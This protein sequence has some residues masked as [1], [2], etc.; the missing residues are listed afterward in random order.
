MTIPP[1]GHAPSPTT[2]GAAGRH[3]AATAEPDGLNTAQL[4]VPGPH[5][6][7][8]VAASQGESPGHA[9]RAPRTTAERQG[10]SLRAGDLIPVQTWAGPAFA[11]PGS[12]GLP[13]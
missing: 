8:D 13:S 1:R 10:L 11:Q 2:K 9:L 4:A 3:F 5:I 6:T 12:A 7:H